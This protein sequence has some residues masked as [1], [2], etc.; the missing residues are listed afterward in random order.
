MNT[1]SP[2]QSSIDSL[3]RNLAKKIGRR[4]PYAFGRVPYTR[5]DDKAYVSFAFDDVPASACR[6]GAS[7]LED[8]GTRATYY[9]SFGLL[10]LPSPSGRIA[11]PDDLQRVVSAGHELGCHTYDHLNGSETDTWL[12]MQSIER[13]AE[14]CSAMF[15]GYTLE[16]FAYPVG[17]PSLELKRAVGKSFLCARG[18]GQAA[19]RKRLDRN[20]LRAFFIDGRNR[21]ER[22]WIHR[23]LAQNRS[24]GGWLIFVTHDVRPD[25][26]IHGCD[27]TFFH[28]VVSAALESGAEVIPVSQVCT[29]IGLSAS[30][31]IRKPVSKSGGS[32][33]EKH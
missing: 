24:R 31:I 16:V 22:N 12:F 9:V 5:R 14:A 15:P 18:G 19:N 4:V 23:E 20:L 28:A 17:P 30:G 8:F 7:I 26:S 21:H 33:N 13:N 2:R 3:Y 29:Q 11:S 6:A 27:P 10:D 1:D 32:I 25:P